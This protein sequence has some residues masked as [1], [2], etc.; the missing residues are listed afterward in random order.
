MVSHCVKRRGYSAG[1]AACSR[2]AARKSSRCQSPRTQTHRPAMHLGLFP[3]AAALQEGT[4]RGVA[5][6][7][8]PNDLPLVAVLQ[9]QLAD[10]LPLLLSDLVVLRSRQQTGREAER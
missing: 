5:L 6:T 3:A 8:L 10:A 1:P 7:C 9:P 2:Q 4:Q